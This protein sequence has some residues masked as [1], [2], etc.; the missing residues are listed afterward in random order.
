MFSD[1][2]VFSSLCEEHTE[3]WKIQAMD[4]HFDIYT[5]EQTKLCYSENEQRERERTSIYFF[6][7]FAQVFLFNGSHKLNLIYFSYI[8][9]KFN[10][11]IFL[12]FFFSF[13][14][15]YHFLYCI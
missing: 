3:G 2:C 7:I 8:I 1:N 11:Q 4:P 15:F 10:L 13:F 12:F 14:L 6:F 9:L 5:M